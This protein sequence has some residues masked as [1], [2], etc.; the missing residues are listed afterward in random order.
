MLLAAASLP[1]T[2]MHVPAHSL[3]LN[4]KSPAVSQH[5]PRLRLASLFLFLMSAFRCF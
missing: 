5:R 1:L 3:H 4:S 2:C